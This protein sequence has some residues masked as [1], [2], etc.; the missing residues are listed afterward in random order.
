MKHIHGSKEEEKVY[1]NH[2]SSDSDDFEQLYQESNEQPKK[3]R[4]VSKSVKYAE[5]DPF[6]QILP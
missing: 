5:T 6:S 1:E 3:P 2:D 4:D